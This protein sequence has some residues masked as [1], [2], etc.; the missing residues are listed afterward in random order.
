MD[1][2]TLLQFTVNGVFISCL[3]ALVALGLTLIFG[4]MHVA[5]FAQGALYMLGAYVSFY[6]V[7]LLG[8]SYFV[9]IPLAMLTTGLVGVLNSTL[10]YRPL[11]GHGG[12]TTF[13]AALG[14]LLILQNAALWA[15]GGH[16]RL[17]PSPFG[18]RKVDLSG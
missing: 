4:V 11:R 8:L 2:T 14:I 1:L 7:T 12:A 18:D 10:V 5:D 6:T 9:S 13:I 16:F 3:Y 17:I 15:F